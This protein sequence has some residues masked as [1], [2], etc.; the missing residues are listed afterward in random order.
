MRLFE[1][2]Y[3]ENTRFDCSGF[4]EL[5]AKELKLTDNDGW[6]PLMKITRHNPQSLNKSLWFIEELLTLVGARGSRGETALMQLLTAEHAGEMNFESHVF[7]KIFNEEK[8]LP[9]E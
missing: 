3:I 5:F 2:K 8:N 4:R 1:S 7:T 6:T 9:G